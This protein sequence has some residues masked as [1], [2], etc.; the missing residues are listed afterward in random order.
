MKKI[1]LLV[2][3]LVFS[4]TLFAQKGSRPYYGGGKHTYSHG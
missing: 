4:I 3:I 1:I 2:A